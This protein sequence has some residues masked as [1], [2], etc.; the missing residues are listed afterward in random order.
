MQFSSNSGTAMQEAALFE[1]YHNRT[2]RSLVHKFNS[3]KNRENRNRDSC[4]YL[5]VIRI[6]FK[7]GLPV[8]PSLGYMVWII[9]GNDSCDA[10]HIITVQ[11]Q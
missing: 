5:L 1:K 6:S 7:Y 10:L 4:S 3:P 2:N 11:L 9:F 8:V